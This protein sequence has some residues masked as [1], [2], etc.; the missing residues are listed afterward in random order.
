M[1][2]MRTTKTL[3]QV[4]ECLHSSLVPLTVDQIVKKTNIINSTV[5]RVIERLVV[6]GEVVMLVYKK[7]I[8]YELVKHNHHHHIQC[9]NCKKLVD[10]HECFVS[11]KLQENVL[12]ETSFSIIK[13]HSVELFGV[14]NECV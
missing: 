8:A 3:T 10:T 6:T 1:I 12:K 14:C 5:Y 11:K 2:L 7:N 4:K 9:L 13:S